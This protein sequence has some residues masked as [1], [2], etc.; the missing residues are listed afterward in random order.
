MMTFPH[1]IL[2]LAVNL[3]AVCSLLHALLPPW[4]FLDG[5]PRAQKYYKLAIYIIGYIALNARS[6]VWQ[7]ISMSK[8]MPPPSQPPQEGA[9]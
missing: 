7:S 9:K 3:I 5:F 8:Q 4:D 6:T 2:T 1:W